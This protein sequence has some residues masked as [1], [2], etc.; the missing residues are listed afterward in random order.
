MKRSSSLG[1]IARLP[2]YAVRGVWYPAVLIS[3]RRRFKSGTAHAF[4]LVERSTISPGLRLPRC[5]PR[6]CRGYTETKHPGA[7]GDGRR[8][9]KAVDPPVPQR[10]VGVSGG[11]GPS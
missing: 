10:G 4:A 8:V 7:T 9:T 11:A 5:S 2:P 1:F 6:G 3:Q